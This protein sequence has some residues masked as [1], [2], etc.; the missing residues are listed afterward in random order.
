[1]LL[2]I[3]VF[4]AITFE[5]C[6]RNSET[7]TH[8]EVLNLLL[9]MPPI[10]FPQRTVQ[11]RDS[12]GFLITESFCYQMAQPRWYYEDWMRRAALEDE[13]PRRDGKD[14]VW[15]ILSDD[16]V[17]A[18]S[19]RVTPGDTMFFVMNWQ[20]PAYESLEVQQAY[21]E[22]VPGRQGSIYKGVR[23]TPESYRRARWWP[24]ADGYGFSTINESPPQLEFTA[25]VSTNGGGV[26][27]L[28]A[29][30]Q[31]LVFEAAWDTLGHGTYWWYGS[32][33]GG[34]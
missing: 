1:M 28:D 20:G 26:S 11:N 25:H 34:W 32:G 33:S 15:E 31:G 12:V 19:L 21:G 6:T 27:I 7:D 10:P 8:V 29:L 18:F 23:D 14:L 4:G 24:T 30:S 13:K 9:D 17:S 16:E 22:V 2:L 5:G 3:L